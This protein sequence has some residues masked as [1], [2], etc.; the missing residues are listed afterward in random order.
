MA[1]GDG[2][3]PRWT[4][5]G[6]WALLTGGGTSFFEAKISR[7]DMRQQMLEGAAPRFGYL[8]LLVLSSVIA[9]LGLIA[10]SAPAIIGAMI[11]APLMMPIVS[12]SY[13]LASLDR[14]IIALAAASILV[15]L[16][17]VL[18]VAYL[19]VVLVGS[20][21]AGDEILSR[22]APTLLDYG[23]ALAAGCAA[24][25]ANARPSIANSIA[26]VAIA[27]SLVP[28][29]AVC[30]ITLGLGEQAISSTGVAIGRIDAMQDSGYDLAGG[31]FL[32]FLANLQAIV[33]IGTITFLAQGYGSWRR[34]IVSLAA[35][36]GMSW[37][38]MQPLADAFFF[39]ELK[40]RVLRQVA[41][42]QA[43]N[44]DA[45]YLDVRNVHAAY[46]D[47]MLHIVIRLIAVRGISPDLQQELDRLRASLERQIGQPVQIVLDLV[48]VH[49]KVLR[50]GPDTAPGPPRDR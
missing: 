35:I 16:G 20:R 25:V 9:T 33:A 11:V 32:L 48:P 38:I 7:W 43:Q 50:S 3:R 21:I 31:A 18:A 45:P 19:G 17:I 1:E 47:G 13:G 37:L 36:A 6:G 15:G 22:T 8:A 12:L 30:G 27:V 14:R 39:F 40:N 5:T 2:R 28:P 34:A 29:L 26:G 23:I 10:N 41:D 42:R 49:Q 4:K 24:A 44:S 46:R